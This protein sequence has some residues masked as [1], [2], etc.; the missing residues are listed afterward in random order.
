MTLCIC[1]HIQYTYIVECTFYTPTV[2][3][4]NVTML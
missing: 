3:Y 2:G 1:E 4:V